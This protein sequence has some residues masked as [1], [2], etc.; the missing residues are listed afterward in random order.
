MGLEN[1]FP[2]KYGCFWIPIWKISR[3]GWMLLGLRKIQKLL[4][5]YTT[6]Q[7]GK[8]N[9]APAPAPQLVHPPGSYPTKR[10]VGKNIKCL[11]KGKDMLLVPR[12]ISL[13]WGTLEANIWGA[14]FYCH[15]PPFLSLGVQ[16]RTAPRGG[17]GHAFA[18]QSA[19]PSEKVQASLNHGASQATI[20][21]QKNISA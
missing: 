18:P 4:A 13:F 11:S 10:E 17:A 16:V 7:P 8:I 6:S 20:L 9:I 12:K 3:G 15:S 14:S 2:F 19:G 21:L 1:V 5:E